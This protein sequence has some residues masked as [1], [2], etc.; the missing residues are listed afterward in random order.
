MSQ[1]YIVLL[2]LKFLLVGEEMEAADQGLGIVLV[3]VVEDQGGESPWGTPDNT[4]DLLN[5]V[6]W[7][8][9]G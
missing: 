7:H 4:F 5:H 8:R 3:K 6:V 2:L 9:L 1:I